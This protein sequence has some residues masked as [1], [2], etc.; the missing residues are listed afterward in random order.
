MT[1]MPLDFL[2]LLLSGESVQ[3]EWCISLSMTIYLTI[4]VFP[5]T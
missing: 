4:T 1:P 3:D 5:I 2:L